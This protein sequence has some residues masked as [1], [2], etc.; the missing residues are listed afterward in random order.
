MS[1]FQLSEV[2]LRVG[3]GPNRAK[4]PER[5]TKPVTV[6][7]SAGPTMRHRIRR[8]VSVERPVPASSGRVATP[9]SWRPHRLLGGAVYPPTCHVRGTEVPHWKG[10]NDQL[11]THRYGSYVR[12]PVG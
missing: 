5:R 12:V 2:E 1:R 6:K 4:L 3:V 9:F 10:Q 8:P 11:K 7:P